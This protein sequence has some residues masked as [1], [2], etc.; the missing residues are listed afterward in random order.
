MR[1]QQSRTTHRAA[2]L[3]QTQ[4]RCY[5]ARQQFLLIRE[6]ACI[7]QGA[8][9]AKKAADQQRKEYLQL[10]QATLVL[11]SAWRARLAKREIACHKAAKKIQDAFRGYMMRQEFQ[12]KR[13]AAVTIQ[14]YARMAAQ[15]RKICTTL[16]SSKHCTETLPGKDTL[17]EAASVLH[18]SAENHCAGTEVVQAEGS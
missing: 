14:A 12:R 2:T 8:Y 9:R 17:S 15:R 6:A 11:Q 13:Q 7:I 5:H 3:I 4:W 18:S 10:Q 1:C 16:D